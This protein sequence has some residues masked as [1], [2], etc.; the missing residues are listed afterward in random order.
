[1]SSQL[2][3]R[4]EAQRIASFLGIADV[5]HDRVTLAECI[6]QGLPADS[7]LTVHKKVGSWTF[8]YVIPEATFRRVRHQAKPLTRETS[9]KLY[10][11]GR[12]YELARCI[13]N[14]DDMRMNRFLNLEHPLLAGRSP[15]EVATSSSAGTD[16]VIDL[17]NRADAGF[18]V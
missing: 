4:T 18:A 12:V 17:L 7:A 14:N 1:M 13:F 16:A 8:F 10:E 6:F 15:L 5:A 3:T 9:E 11:F 2:T